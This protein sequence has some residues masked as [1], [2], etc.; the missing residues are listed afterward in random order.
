MTFR[1]VPGTTF[2]KSG[3]DLHY[4]GGGFLL[5]TTFGLC[6]WDAPL[7]STGSERHD[8]RRSLAF[9]AQLLMCRSTVPRT[10]FSLSRSP[11]PAERRHS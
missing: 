8:H 2:L 5:D 6:C 4:P 11:R 9:T 10:W 1:D 7:S 3:K